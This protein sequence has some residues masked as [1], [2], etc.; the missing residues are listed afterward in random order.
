MPE[1][2]R[3]LIILKPKQP[4]LNWIRTL[5]DEDNDLTL[6]ELAEDSTAYLIPELW[7]DSDQQELLESHYDVLFEEQLGGWWTDEAAWPKKRDLTMFLDWFD[8]EFHSLVFDLCD[9]P[10]RVIDESDA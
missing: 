9:E 10:I 2:D 5:D 6:E 8:V 7:E 4:F 3:S 1:I